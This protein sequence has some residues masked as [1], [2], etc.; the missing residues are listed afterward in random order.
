[1]FYLAFVWITVKEAVDKQSS[2]RGHVEGQT[3]GEVK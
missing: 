2:D 3:D 1:M